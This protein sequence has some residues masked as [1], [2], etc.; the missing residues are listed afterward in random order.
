MLHQGSKHNRLTMFIGIALVLGIIT[1][2][3]LNK[4][5]VGREN[6]QML[7][8]DLQLSVLRGRQL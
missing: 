2:F 5:Y 1:G 6:E 4:S 8:A 7:N 3:V